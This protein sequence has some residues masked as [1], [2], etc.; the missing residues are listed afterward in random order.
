[1]I[2][3]ALEYYGLITDLSESGFYKTGEI[4]RLQKRVK[5]QVLRSGKL[6]VISGCVGSGKTTFINRLMRD[7]KKEGNCIVSYSFSTDR[8]RV[9][10]KTLSSALIF[11][12]S[13][14]YSES[15]P[16]HTEVR[17]RKLVRLME[18][19]NKPVVLFIDEAQDLHYNTLSSLK[20]LSEAAARSDQQFSIVLTGQPKLKN[21]LKSTRMEEIGNRSVF[22]DIAH[23]FDNKEHYIQW[24]IKQVL[25][26][27][28][29]ISDIITPEAIKRLARLESP[30]QIIFNFNKALEIGYLSGSK[31][32]TD[33]IITEA[34]LSQAN[35]VEQKYIRAGYQPNT[36]SKLTHIPEKTII[37]YFANRLPEQKKA[38]V[39]DA[40]SQANIIT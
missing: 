2:F 26:K 39:E 5:D 30:L 22:I 35:P 18:E 8:E 14:N 23:I 15:V 1:M 25:E 24:A 9:D 16:T 27:G 7:L 33:E 4:E 37:Q 11:D 36:I 21:T 12:L 34:L 13:G 6:F 28:K 19:H 20:K 3:D 40:I 32:I 38:E 31:I 29:N 17:D 10:I